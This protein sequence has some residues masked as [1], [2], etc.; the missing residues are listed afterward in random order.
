MMLC[1]HARVALIERELEELEAERYAALHRHL[2]VCEACSL[3][4]RQGELLL[5]DLAL[6]RGE[7]PREIDVTSRV[8]S[9]IAVL[10]SPT[11]DE[12]PVRQW[13]LVAMAAVF[14][15]VVILGALWDLL[16]SLIGPARDVFT[17]MAGARGIAA[18]LA[19]PIIGLLTIPFK[20]VGALLSSLSAMAPMLERLAPLGVGL[21]ALATGSMAATVV[22]FV[23]R[24][25]ITRPLQDTMRTRS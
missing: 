23:G 11:G 12:L 7:I 20:L 24:D 8:M 16:P 9:E 2:Q 21:A 25:I 5:N 13:A 10:G 22:Y 15:G 3:E 4:A 19:A 18:N 14:G 17:V 6:L 1:R